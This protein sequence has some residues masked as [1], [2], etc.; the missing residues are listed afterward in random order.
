[1]MNLLFL[2]KTDNSRE[3]RDVLLKEIPELNFLIWPAQCE[4]KEK[5]DYILAWNPPL[6]EIKKF[7][8]LKAVLSLGAGVDGLLNDPNLPRHIPIIRLIDSNLTRGMTEYIIFWTLFYHRRMGDYHKLMKKGNWSQFPQ[9]ETAKKRVGILGAGELGLDAARHLK[10]LN[11]DVAIWSKNLKSI[12]D[13]HC[14]TDKSGFESI[15]KHSEILIC[16]LPLTT[17]TANI[18]NKDAFELMPKGSVIINCGRGGHLVE[19]DLLDVIDSG[20]LHAATL[21]VFRQEPL[22]PN[23]PFWARE[24]IFLTPHMASLTFPRSAARSIS[25]SIR[26]IESGQI[27]SNTVDLDRGY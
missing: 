16:L 10:L 24:N 1:M 23:H 19:T 2:S 5:V 22:P 26:Q 3:W 18:L 4:P 17:E 14:F 6:G 11:F 27:P 7:P 21:D 8:N 25:H 15:L 12:K 9:T 13:M 20:Q